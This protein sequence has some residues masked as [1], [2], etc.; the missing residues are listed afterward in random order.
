MSDHD[1]VL[2]KAYDAR[3]MWRLLGYL[4]P[5]MKMVAL[6]LCAIV[7][8]S[9]L[10]LAQPYLTK[11]A[12]DDHIRTGTLEGLDDIAL[13]FVVVLVGSFV[14]EYLQT[15]TMQ[16]MGQRI[17]FD[18]R[19]EIYRH[20]QRLD[21]RFYDKS[22]VGRLMTRV[23]TDVETLNDLFASGVI[24]VFRDVFM[25]LGIMVVLLVLDWRLA[26]TAFSVLPLIAWVTHW[27]RQNARDS[28]RQVRGWI[29]RINGFL[30][31]NITG[32]ATV[33]VYGRERQNFDQFDQ[34]NSRHRD[35]HVDSIF[36]Y[37]TFYPAIELIGA[38]ATALLLWYGG[39]R[40]VQGTV[41]LGA[42]VAFL[43]YAQRFFKPISDLSEKFNVMQSAMASSERIFD[44]LDTPVAITSPSELVRKQ[45]RD[46]GHIRFENVSFA[47]QDDDYV[48]RNVTFEVAPGERIGVVGA[49]GAGKTTLI[50]LLMRFYDVNSGRITIDGVD[51]REMS[52]VDLRKQFGLVLQDVYLFSGS[53]RDN[54]RLGHEDIDDTDVYTAAAS[55]HAD[56]FIEQLPEG[57]DAVVLER[58]ATLSVGQRQL[59]SFARALAFKPEVLVLDEATSSVDTETERVIQEALQVLMKGRTTIAIAH[60]LSTVQGMDKILVF[61]KGELREVGDHQ[62]LLSRRGLY[63][64]LYQL[65][66]REQERVLETV[67]TRIGS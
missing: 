55:V 40:V 14:F 4:R 34:I 26:L 42:L 6:A 3:L 50:N 51:I 65:Q 18:L 54:I 44:L 17:M 20:L 25:L 11:L 16:L 48:L 63:H 52:L 19:L 22:P 1:E 2:G 32:M 41:E 31:E 35:A 28:Y 21:L 24:S 39:G 9:L 61:H 56:R 33:Q 59:L 12:I 57:F 23:T 37:A 62:T 27:F 10:Q 53:V 60:R 43:Q 67:T 5:H 38:L 58:G 49:T 64:T 7:G 45:P 47:Y 66:Y 8:Y 30:Q 13:V 29:A 15:Y 46:R 36:Y